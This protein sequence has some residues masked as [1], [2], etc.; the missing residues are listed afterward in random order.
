MRELVNDDVR[1]GDVMLAVSSDIINAFNSL[2]WSV[3]RLPLKAKGVPEYL[4]CTLGDYLSDR[5]LVY[6]D[7]DDLLIRST[8]TYGVPKGLILEPTLWNV[9]YD[10]ILRLELL[11]D[12]STV[13]YAD[14]ILLVARGPSFEKAFVRAELTIMAS[15]HNN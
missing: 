13:C 14:D 2:A 10:L 9:D 5:Y 4:K 3:I 12:C 7:R 1:N 6:V 8:M 11:M 15:G